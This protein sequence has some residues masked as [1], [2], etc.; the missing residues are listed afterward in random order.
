MTCTHF[1]DIEPAVSAQ[2]KGICRFCG[3]GRMFRN[4]LDDYDTKRGRQVPPLIIKRAWAAEAA[5][6]RRR[7]NER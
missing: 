4:S 1:W 6:V 7:Q 2:S 5:P 3:E